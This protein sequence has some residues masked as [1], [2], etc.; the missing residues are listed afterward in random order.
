MFL[1]VVKRDNQQNKYMTG[2]TVIGTIERNKVGMERKNV[3]VMAALLIR[4]VRE[5]LL[6]RCKLL[7]YIKHAGSNSNSP[8]GLKY[9][10]ELLP[11]L[12]F[13]V[14]VIVI[15]GKVDGEKPGGAPN[16]CN[17]YLINLGKLNNQRVFSDFYPESGLCMAI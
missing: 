11:I 1:W 17:G 8:L 10:Y 9:L 7:L 4:L 6:R 5:S 16:Y 2:Y 3:G 14:T 12:I 13:L 15:L